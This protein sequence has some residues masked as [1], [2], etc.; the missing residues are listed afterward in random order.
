[1]ASTSKGKSGR[2][3]ASKGEAA[4][5]VEA[6]PEAASETAQAVAAADE[7]PPAEAAPAAPHTDEGL[8]DI[9]I[10]SEN[11]SVRLPEGVVGAF[12]RH[13]MALQLWKPV[14]EALAET[15]GEVYLE[16]WV[17]SHEMFVKGAWED[18]RP[19][20]KEAVI[21]FGSKPVP[22]PLAGAE[23]EAAFL[24]TFYGCQFDAPLGPFR[25][26]I[27]DL[28]RVRPAVFTGPHA[29]V[30]PRREVP[31]DE[32]RKEKKRRE[33]GPGLAGTRVEEW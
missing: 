28:M 18:A 29:G 10:L 11:R 5:P 13:G 7:A 25:K 15:W 8:Y 23:A 12:I 32:Q 6:A 17:A 2:G 27:L 31:P 14:D 22:A 9:T 20:F 1:M 19:I 21:R 33:L 30:P 26:K 4:A 16:P 3:K 24:M